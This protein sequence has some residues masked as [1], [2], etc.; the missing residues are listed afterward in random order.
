MVFFY[1][2]ALSK[3]EKIHEGSLHFVE[4]DY[5]SKY[6]KLLAK[7]NTTKLNVNRMKSL[8]TEIYKTLN[9]VNLSYMKEI[10]SLTS[11]RYSTQ[12]PNNISLSRVDYTTFGLKSITHEGAKLWNHLHESLKSAENFSIFKKLIRNWSGSLCSCNYCKF[13]TSLPSI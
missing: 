13:P 5:L 8:C 2:K 4:D 10:F 12:G 7:Y 9:E 1:A 11:S 3:I 6:E